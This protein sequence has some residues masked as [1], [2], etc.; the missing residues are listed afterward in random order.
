M[1]RYTGI[2]R[3][4]SHL[5]SGHISSGECVA[6]AARAAAADLIFRIRYDNVTIYH[7]DG[8]SRLYATKR[9]AEGCNK[10]QSEYVV[11]MEGG[12]APDIRE[13]ASFHVIVSRIKDMND[14]AADNVIIG[15]R[16]RNLFIRGGEGIAADKGKAIIDKDSRRMIFD[17][18]AGVCEASDGAQLLMV[19]VSC[20]E[21]MLIAAKQATGQTA[22]AGGVGIMGSQGRFQKLHT[23]DITKAIDDQIIRQVNAGVT[24]ILVSPGDFC[25]QKI[26]ETLHLD[27]KTSIFCNNYPGEAIDKAVELG[28]QNLLLVGNAGKLIKLAAGIMNTDS[29]ASDGRR[30]IFAAHTSL[31]GGNSNQ[32]RAVMNC[33]T[34]DEMLSALETFGL[35]ERVMQSI[36]SAIDLSVKKRCG[37]RLK[38]GI[39]LYSEEF[40]LLGQTADTKNVLVKVSQEQYSLSLKLK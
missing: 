6:A 30:E 34:V 26:A 1:D 20:P 3:T 39:V 28:V 31:V 5:Q 35:R 8:T 9:V 36:M 25:A 2:N 23:R 11:A 12:A 38:A 32:V 40:G 17:A 18:V 15:S 27:L 22:F 7:P 4:V 13:K 33:R 24:S 10:D 21:G 16:F 14:M 29:K 19:T 37:G